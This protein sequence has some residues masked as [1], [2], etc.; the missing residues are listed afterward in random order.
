MIFHHNCTCTTILAESF[1]LLVIYGL[2]L[3]TISKCYCNLFLWSGHV[4]VE[5]P[6]PKY[7]VNVL[8][9]QQCEVRTV[10]KLKLWLKLFKISIMT[11]INDQEWK[12]IQHW[13][14]ILQLAVDASL[15]MVISHWKSKACSGCESRWIFLITVSVS[16]CICCI[17]HRISVF[18]VLIYRSFAFSYIPWKC[19][20]FIKRIRI[21]IIR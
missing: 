16:F 1:V 15:Q 14:Q 5:T 11:N 19:Y 4:K 21:D 6:L 13:L 7:L 8:T 3:C 17:I 12:K 18:K 2:I 20:F 10:V 9:L